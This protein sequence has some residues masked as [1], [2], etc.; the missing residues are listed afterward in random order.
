MVFDKVYILSI[1]YLSH[2]ID[3][4]Y[5]LSIGYLGHGIW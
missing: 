4:V 1:G 2:G 3:K 5:I